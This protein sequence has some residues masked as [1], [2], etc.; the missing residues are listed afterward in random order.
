ML[1]IVGSIWLGLDSRRR[2]TLID[3]N[4]GTVRV[5]VGWSAREYPLDALHELTLHV[6]KPVKVSKD[7]GEAEKKTTARLFLQI[8]RKRYV[9]LE[10]EFHQDA[11]RHT[12][13]KLANVTEQLAGELKVSWSQS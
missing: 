2:D 1:A 8:G 10:T 13:S 5:Q 6:P 12:Q 4:R 11:H 9:L 7:A 3:W